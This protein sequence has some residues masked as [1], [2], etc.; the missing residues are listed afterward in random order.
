MPE[1]SRQARAWSAPVALIVAGLTALGLGLRL[2]LFDDSLF[3][4]ELSTYF[5]VHGFGQ[6]DVIDLVRSGQEGTPPLYYLLAW[7][8]QGI[9]DYS[10]GLRVVPMLAGVASIPLTYLLGVRTIGRAAA[11]VGTTLVALSPFLIFYSA[12]ARGYSLAMLMTVVSAL[13]L[14]RALE[15]NRWSWW[16]LYALGAAGAIYSHYTAVFVLIG[17]FGWALLA[18]P[19]RRRQ[20]LA[21]TAVA[22]VLFV[23]WLPGFIDDRDQPPA[24]I[25]EAIH[26][27]T[28]QSAYDDLLH[29]SVELHTEPAELIPPSS[30]SVGLIEA[31]LLLGLLG[32]AL[33]SLRPGGRQDTGRPARAREP[34]RGAEL[35]WPPPAGLTLIVILALATPVGAALYSLLAPSVYL[36]RNLIASWPALGLLFGAIVTAPRGGLR[37]AAV[38]ALLAGFAI[39]GTARLDSDD[40]R[41]DYAAAVD[42]IHDGTRPGAPVLEVPQLGP[43]PQ[44]A[45]EAASAPAGEAE[46]MR[47]PVLPLGMAPLQARIQS[48]GPEG[49]GVFARLP[50]PSPQAFA[51]RVA[52]LAGGAR[53]AVVTW[54]PVPGGDLEEVDPE[55]PLGQFLADLPPGYHTV[56]K[57]SFPAIDPSGITVYLLERMSPG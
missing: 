38:A 7:L 34:S 29:W 15:Q 22:A 23:P 20:L 46:P 5:V 39:S 4:D 43:G 30:L 57:R 24:R 50:A 12:E 31:G 26:P 14:V 13:G 6:G 49:G 21:A 32:L 19:A 47:N 8:T 40:Q 51:R 3:G 17:Q 35:T 10:E 54:G 52:D 56:E 9:G 1:G 28:L 42:F 48:R 55:T 33:R 11:L 36:P 41:P 44:T 53:I 27:F 25:I 18:Y 45:L 16:G 37:I 2:P